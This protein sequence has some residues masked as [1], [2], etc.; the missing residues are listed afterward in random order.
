MHH[1][2]FGIL[3]SKIDGE[4]SPDE[5]IA[6]LLKKH[7]LPWS[8]RRSELNFEKVLYSNFSQSRVHFKLSSTL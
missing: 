8:Q 7:L 2:S 5:A 4:T 3:P 6:A 1:S